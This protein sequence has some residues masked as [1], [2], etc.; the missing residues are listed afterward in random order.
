MAKNYN[1][2][3]GT[4][5]AA[6][7]AFGVGTAFAPGADIAM[8]SGTWLTMM[9]AIADRSG[10]K[11]DKVFW[12]KVLSSMGVGAA[13]YWAGSKVFTGILFWVIPGAGTITAS[14]VN[15]LLNGLYTWRIGTVFAH[16][17]DKPDIDLRDVVAVSACL[18]SALGPVPTF[19]EVQHVWSMIRT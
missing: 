2:I 9:V 15:G 8:V 3:I 18:R 14:T 7:A 5:V 4:A 11:E 19:G 1:D 13:G 12:A 10:H 16:M 17:F 6:A